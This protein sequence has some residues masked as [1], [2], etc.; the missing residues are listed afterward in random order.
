[1]NAKQIEEEK[2]LKELSWLK[3]EAAYCN[4][5]YGNVEGLPSQSSKKISSQNDECRGEKELITI[6]IHQ[7]RLLLSCSIP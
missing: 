4:S 2:T 5:D 1:M 7:T 3:C 6:F